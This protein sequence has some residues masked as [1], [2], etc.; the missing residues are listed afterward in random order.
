M[1]GSLRNPAAFCG[2][3]G[4]RPSAGLVPR[5]PAVDSW[6]ALSV[7][8]PM[9]R[10]ASDL[11]L[12]VGAMAGRTPPA[13]DRDFKGVRIAWWIDLGGVPFD[14]RITKVVNAR[15][16]LFDS[17]GCVVEDAEPD[18][19]GADATFK[20]LRARAFVMQHGDL[21][22]RW[23]ELVKETIVWEIERGERLTPDEISLASEHRV[24]LQQ[25][26][27]RFLEPYEFFV[28]P[29]TQVPPFDV[30]QPYVREID[31]VAMATY[32][33]WMKSCYFV[34]V[35]GNPAIS[36]PCGFTPEGL[37][38]GLQIVGRSGD[39]WGLIQLAHAFET[40]RGS[41]PGPP[42]MAT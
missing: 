26:V 5:A 27:R 24:A 34:S 36:V 14:P 29:T 17:F 6:A 4:L 18:F 32:I 10:S 2:V 25:R 22:R 40:A 21:V 20:T 8:G 37:P 31:G 11:A 19:T 35:A 28:L 38:V 1:G 30:N 33:D 13:L 39:D 7:D 9:A 42:A 16:S 3:V 41:W 12:L 23:R 15:R